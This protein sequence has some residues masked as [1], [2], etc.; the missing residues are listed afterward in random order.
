MI[1]KKNKFSYWFFDL[2]PEII[3]K[4]IFVAKLLI[5][6]N[7][8]LNNLYTKIKKETNYDV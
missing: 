1:D 5:I 6:V 3:I 2:F 8:N 4:N 7:E